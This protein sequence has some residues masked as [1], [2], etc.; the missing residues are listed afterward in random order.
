[1]KKLIK[2]LEKAEQLASEFSGGYSGE[3]L[4]A[5]EF[6]LALQDRITR[7]KKGEY[8]V[9]ED[10]WIWFAPTCQ[11]DDFIGT[12]GEYLANTIFEQLDKLKR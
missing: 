10:L 12:D 7:L 4:S 8:V 6:Y 1:L 2:N 9:L 5:E 11:W 3:F